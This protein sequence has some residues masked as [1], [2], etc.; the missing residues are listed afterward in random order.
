MKIMLVGAG[1]SFSIKDVE[2][3]YFE[4]FQELGHQTALFLLD[5]RIAIAGKW[6][7]YW[8]RHAQ[9]SDPTKKPTFV[10]A[11]YDAGVKALEMSL[12]NRTDWVIVVSAMYLHP[13]VIVMMRRAGLKICV[14]FTESPYEDEKQARVASI[15]NVCFTNERTSVEYLRSANPNVFYLPHAYSPARHS[16]NQVAPP[17]V[18]AS[19]SVQEKPRLVC[20]PSVGV[21]VRPELLLAHT[22]SSSVDINGGPSGHDVVFVGSGFQERIDLLNRVDWKGIGVN[23]GL[24]GT[25]NLLGSRSKLRPYVEGGIISNNEAVDLY[26][27]SKIALNLYRT[28]KGY[29]HTVDHI[30]GAESLNPRAYE[31]AASGTFCLT[32][33]R[34]EGEEVFGDSQPAFEGVDDLERGIIYYLSHPEKRLQCV[35]EAYAKVQEHTFLARARQVLS[36]LGQLGG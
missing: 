10:D 17:R 24:Y 32:D 36:T 19:G 25:W 4:A 30:S 29:G 5:Y 23:L 3:G 14:L 8:W 34:K 6:L 7:N 18:N 11:I 31:L 26:R 35:S 21:P 16:L 27:G 15:A 1:A 28:S 13:D 33:F 9:R 22:N 20:V 12:R 2:T